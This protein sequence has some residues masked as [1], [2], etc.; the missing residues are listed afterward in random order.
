V[1]EHLESARILRWGRSSLLN[2]GIVS[3][4]ASR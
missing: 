1:D 4:W 3:G 2:E